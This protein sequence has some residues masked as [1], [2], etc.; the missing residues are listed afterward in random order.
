MSK[1]YPRISSVLLLTLSLSVI[2]CSSES[3]TQNNQLSPVTTSTSAVAN[4][5]PTPDPK[6]S[7][8]PLT[9]APN[10]QENNHI[11]GIVVDPNNP[12]IFYLGTH[13]GLI[14]YSEAGKW[15][16]VGDDR[17]DY[18]G[19][20]ADPKQSG[21][22][23]SSGHPPTGGN[24]GFRVTE[25]YGQ[26]WR[27][28]SKSGVDFHA[29]AVAPSNPNLIYGWAT[30]GEQGFL[31]S[32]DGGKNWDSITP[33]G[34]DNAVF[35]LTV[36]PQ[37]PDHLYAT[38]QGGLYESKNGGQNWVLIPGT[39]TAPM[40]GLTIVSTANQ[41]K[42]IGYRL[43]E[44]DPGIYQSLDGGK[45]WNNLGTGTEGTILYLTVAPNNPNILYAVNDQNTVFKSEDGGKNWRSLG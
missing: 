38:T 27:V 6:N 30:S 43:L 1:I 29:L 36:N 12:N 16:W 18:M 31:V 8:I 45:A 17:S 39:E 37:H 14:Q 9:P 23:Y 20:T 19:L 22:L 44:S 40:I 4:S 13:E 32:K 35:S 25:D 24:L 5:Q 3:V 41:T 11:H 42:M 28:L 15:S 7:N 21:R 33:I 2:S 34:L 26:T 10:W